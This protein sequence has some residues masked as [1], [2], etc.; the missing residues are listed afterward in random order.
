MTS[1]SFDLWEEISSSSFYTTAV[2]HRSLRDGIALANK[3]GQTSVV[4][5]YTSQANNILCF[6][7][8]CTRTLC[9]DS[10]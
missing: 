8:V 4:S 1:I 5:G 6:L 3:I 7:Q 9:R 10:Y 2:Q